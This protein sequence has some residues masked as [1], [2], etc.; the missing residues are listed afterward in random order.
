MASL[1]P[2]ARLNTLIPQQG[3]LEVAGVASEGLLEGAAEG[4]AKREQVSTFPQPPTQFM[5]LYTAENVARGLAPKLPP[6]PHRWDPVDL[7][8]AVPPTGTGAPM[9]SG[10][11]AL[12]GAGG[13]PA[14]GTGPIG[15]SSLGG[16]L[17]GMAGL[18]APS[19]CA[20]TPQTA[21]PSTSYMYTM[22]GGSY[23]GE[24]HTVRSLESQG[25]RRLHPHGFD[26][27]RELKKLNLSALVNFLDL[28]DIL[29]LA[30]DS[31][32]RT[33]KLSGLFVIANT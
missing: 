29:I 20:T 12:S 4:D 32:K 28:L 14:T 2:L 33:E 24:D 17:S 18:A 31:P 8:G 25:I 19:T 23:S 26:H 6:P 30:P 22:F 9:P 21:A 7:G 3:V 15:S 13:Q 11:G 10:L 16:S 5:C 27:R 1:T